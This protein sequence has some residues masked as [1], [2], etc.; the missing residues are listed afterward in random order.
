MSWMTWSWAEADTLSLGI[1]PANSSSQ[2]Q[3]ERLN[4]EFRAIMN[5]REQLRAQWQEDAHCGALGL[6][7]CLLSR[8]S[9][10]GVDLAVGGEFVGANTP[11][12]HLS[13]VDVSTETLVLTLA[14]GVPG[15]TVGG[16]DLRDLDDVGLSDA[17]AVG[18][19]RDQLVE[20][21]VSDGFTGFGED[22]VQVLIA[23]V[24]TTLLRCRISTVRRRWV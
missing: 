3:A 22:L 23:V 24:E 4:T 12:L 17:N 9:D 5:S 10:A 21:G 6:V 1:R 20:T 8:G 19:D 15:G 2:E 7:D 11:R 16:D 13:F 14:L 18:E